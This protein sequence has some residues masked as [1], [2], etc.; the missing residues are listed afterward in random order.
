MPLWEIYHPQ[1]LFQDPSTKAALVKDIVSMY[2][3]IGLPAFYVVTQFKPLAADDYW[4][5]EGRVAD[6][7]QEAH[8]FVRFVI[9]HIAVRLPDQD[10]VYRSVT[11]KIDAIISPYMGEDDNWE[12]HVAETERRLWKING[13]VPPPF[14]SEQEKVWAKENRAV[15]YD[16]AYP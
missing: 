7:G 12:Y 4:Q 13:M 3:S 10:E 8:H 2:T 16:G 11:S 5:G 9:T 6:G 14:E 15:L 1:A